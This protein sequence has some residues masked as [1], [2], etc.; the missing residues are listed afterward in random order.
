MAGTLTLSQSATFTATAVVVGHS[1]AAPKRTNVNYI[2]GLNSY[3]GLKAQNNVVSLGHP[4]CTEQSFAKF[5]SSLRFTPQGR[6]SGGGALTSTCN[7]V[8]EIF[9]I[10]GV[11]NGL[12]LVGVAIGFVLLRIEAAV[13]EAE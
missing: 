3:S 4:V 7:A 1:R 5:V 12:V 8:A 2:G 10:A 13:E 11:M 9:R 6:K